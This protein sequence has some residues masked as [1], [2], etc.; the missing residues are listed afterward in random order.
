[1]TPLVDDEVIIE[2]IKKN[3][4]CESGLEPAECFYKFRDKYR[5]IPYLAYRV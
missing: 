3:A 5:N 4:L 2:T 1:M